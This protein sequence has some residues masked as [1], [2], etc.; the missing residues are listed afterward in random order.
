MK[1]LLVVIAVTLMLLAS[2][3]PGIA[4]DTGENHIA[5]LIVDY[6]EG[7]ISYALVPFTEDT[8]SGFELLDRSGL[9]LLTVQFGGLGNGVCAIEG[10]GCDLA[11]CRTRLCQ[12]GDPAS[13]FWH[14][15]QY[16]DATWVFAPLGASASSVSDGGLDAWSWSS[17][18][19][20]PGPMA[21]DDLAARLD[22]DLVSMRADQ[23]L[24]PAV[25]TIGESSQARQRAGWA[26]IAA[27]ALLAGLAVVGVAV[28]RRTRSS[29]PSS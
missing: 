14:Y 22:V 27:S 19:P 29:V 10:T 18:S 15:A 8:L 28:L 11:A 20:N 13:P 4:A 7:R 23:D 5:G 12:T 25:M 26:E 3:S 21:L 1:R 17:D 24:A 9:S 6:G 2:A 16:R